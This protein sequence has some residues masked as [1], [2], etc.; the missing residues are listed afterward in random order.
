MKEIT[1]KRLKKLTPECSV[2]DC[3]TKPLS[4][5]L[6]RKHYLQIWSKGRLYGSTRDKRP[7]IVEGDIAKIPL[8]LN[9]KDGYAVVDKEFSY[10][11]KY[12]WSVIKVRDDNRYYY[13][14]AKVDGK[15]QLLHRVV[16]G[17][18]DGLV[19]DHINHD[20]LDNRKSNLRVCTASEN[21]MNYILVGATL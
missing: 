14:Q 21:R 7:A 13:A 20:T 8:G 15:M 10:L 19:T 18:P 16:A 17:T 1:V 11:D 2:D 12:N 5:N 4:R 3:S 9:A 6:C